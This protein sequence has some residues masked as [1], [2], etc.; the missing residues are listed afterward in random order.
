MGVVVS[1]PKHPPRMTTPHR[2]WKLLSAHASV[3]AA[4]CR[5][6]GLASVEGADAVHAAGRLGRRRACAHEGLPEGRK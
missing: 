3:P 2:G 1:E 4:L 5:G 6:A